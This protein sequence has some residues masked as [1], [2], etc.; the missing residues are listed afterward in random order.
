MKFKKW[1]VE[2]EKIEITVLE[3]LRGATN[4]RPTQS[5]A[6]NRGQLW[7]PSAQFGQTDSMTPIQKGI[8]GLATGIGSSIASELD[9]EVSPQPSILPLELDKE[10][11]LQ[12]VVLP[13][14]Y[15]E[16]MNMTPNSWVK[17]RTLM[18]KVGPV[19]DLNKINYNAEQKPGKYLFPDLTN[20]DLTNRA[21]NFTK[22]LIFN[23]LKLKHNNTHNKKY[24]LEDPE[25]LLED[26]KD[27]DNVSYLRLVV[28]YKRRDLPKHID[29]KLSGQSAYQGDQSDN[30]FE[31]EL[32]SIARAA[33]SPGEGEAPGRES[34]RQKT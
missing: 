2:N 20:D 10:P 21:V 22:G 17:P 3:A 18:Y 12:T 33:R 29:D 32:V 8:G 27:I 30:D 13:L 6:A 15:S 7:G 34:D 23:L 14:Q 31:R 1:F 5:F 26:R 11:F 19:F 28:S 25:I 9:R 24:I 16:D 4:A